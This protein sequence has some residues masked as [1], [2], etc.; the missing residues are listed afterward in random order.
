M[1]PSRALSPALTALLAGL[2]TACGEGT[3]LEGSVTPLLDLRYERAEAQG[4]EDELSVRFITPQGTGENT[5]LKVTAK[6]EN[7]T[8]APGTPIDLTETL[9]PPPSDVQ[10]GEVSRSVLDEPTRGFPRIARGTLTFQKAL[11]PG[12]KVSGDFHVTF[13]QGTDVYSGRT[14]FGHFEATVP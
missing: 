14:L 6:R 12:A 11:Q 7:L 13:V 10:R 3:R 9:G 4:T 1:S 5:V 2:L 8:F